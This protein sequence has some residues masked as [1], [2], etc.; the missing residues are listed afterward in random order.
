VAYAQLT[1]VFTAHEAS[2]H[3]DASTLVLQNMDLEYLRAVALNASSVN[4]VA[5][6]ADTQDV[7]IDIMH[8]NLLTYSD[9][10]SLYTT[11]IFM[12]NA[13]SL[14]FYFSKFELPEGAAVF[15]LNEQ[16][17]MV[18]P[19]THESRWE[20]GDMQTRHL[21]GNRAQIQVFHSA[22]VEPTM[23]GLKLET[24]ATGFTDLKAGACN[25]NVICKDPVNTCNS[26]CRI[27]SDFSCNIQCT[28]RGAD[29]SADQFAGL[30]WQNQQDSIVGILTS[31]GS[32]YCSGAFIDNQSRR[33]YVLTANH[34]TV[35]SS[36]LMQVDFFNPSCTSNS[37]TAGDTSRSVGNLNVLVSDSSIDHALVEI[38]NTVPASWNVFLSGYDATCAGPTGVVGIHHPS[39]ANMKISGSDASMVLRPYSS[40]GTANQWYVPYWTE[41]TT[42]PGSS[43]SPLFDRTTRRIIGQLHGGSARCPSFQGFDMYGAICF[44]YNQAGSANMNSFLG[45][46]SMDGRPL[47]A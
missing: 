23:I 25:I 29:S 24:I 9:E 10:G 5:H 40:W 44:S 38:R 42:E 45:A 12:E 26:A 1:Q 37:N 8:S 46:S 47:Y 15:I 27:G 35:S 13:K 6:I 30:D 16:G 4:K 2:W 43:G 41:S 33:Q 7:D 3:P 32:R 28:F 17:D 19:L 22:A 18:G 36:D 31:R 21:F 14:A 20:N 34:C 11:E 39:G